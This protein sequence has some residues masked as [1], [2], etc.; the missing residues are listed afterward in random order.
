MC[1]DRQFIHSIDASILVYLQ[2]NEPS[3]ELFC[4]FH[5]LRLLARRI[6]SRGGFPDDTTLHVDFSSEE[7][8]PETGLVIF[9]LG[10]KRARKKALFQ[11]VLDTV[12]YEDPLA[13]DVL[14]TKMQHAATALRERQMPC[15]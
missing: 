2:K 4:T 9:R 14:I 1:N 11:L 5:N 13:F 7:D 6:A 3:E 10:R 12:V 8:D 15:N